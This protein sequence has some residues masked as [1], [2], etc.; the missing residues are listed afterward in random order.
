M[1]GTW[2]VT[3]NRWGVGPNLGRME[4]SMPFSF[5][6]LIPYLSSLIPLLL[7]LALVPGAKAQQGIPHIGY[8]YP[9]GGRQGAS[10]QVKIGGQF[11]SGATHAYVSGAGIQAVV[12]ETTKP[13][14]QK[15][16]KNLRERLKELMKKSKDAAVQKE[17]A[18]IRKKLSTFAPKANPFLAETVQ[19]QVTIAPD[20]EPGERELRLGTRVGLS[21]PLA[22]HVSQQPE[23]VENEP[24]S[25]KEP[26]PY[27]K[28]QF[29]RFSKEPARNLTEPVVD[30]TLPVIVNGQIL[31]G[32]VDYYRFKA[33]KGQQLV[34]VAKAR[35]LIPYLA[36]AVPG[37]F[38]AVLALYDAKG[39]ELAYENNFRFHPDPVLSCKIPSDGEYTLE[40]RDALYR[41]REDF[42]YR[43]TLAELPFVTSIFPLGGRAGTQTA[44]QME[45]WNLPQNRLTVDTKGRDPGTFPLFFKH[46]GLASNQ[47]P[48]AVDTLPEC[49]EQ[50][51]NNQPPSAQKV[52]LP[53]IVNG[54]I[55]VPGDVDVFQF[56]GRA[57][58]AL[59]A[60][61]MAR[62]LDSP[63]D[64]VLKLTDAAGKQLAF[65]DDHEDKGSG[66]NTHH[67]DS[68]IRT[69][70]P[71]DGTYYLH[72]SD[73][74]RQGSSAHAYRLRISSPRPDFQLRLV[75]SS[76]LARPG[77]TVPITVY[78]LRKDG[79]NQK[80]ALSLKSALK[81]FSLGG[82]WVPP[83][84]DQIRL[85]LTV[86]PD[87]L[88]KPFNLQLE[89]RAM[90][91]GQEIVHP[92]VPADDL[93]QAFFYHHLVPAK[94]LMVTVLGGTGRPGPQVKLLAEEPVKLSAGGTA[95]VRFTSSRGGA[96][97]PQLELHEPPE[98]I[99]IQKTSVDRGSVTLVLSAD[100]KVK[101]G[102][103][104]NLIVQASP[105][106]AAKAPKPKA[107]P[108]PG[109]VPSITLP[110]IP[111]E[112][113]K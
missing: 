62:R 36:D 22:F 97:S 88:E 17:I 8:V 1:H 24:N 71:A 42:V 29:A 85:T 80:I 100:P 64:S 60:E 19:L 112:I 68:L 86:P 103:Q 27:K 102:L 31:P 109:R 84:Q 75:P 20:A 51:P 43:L 9:A 28:P 5:S 7:L 66:L 6:S 96:A 101:P 4:R 91:Q 108:N 90:I 94:N 35:D 16:A 105:G 55:D 93:M 18:E 41:G 59:V 44:V 79:F 56:E 92:V 30:V 76:I 33:T 23:F 26:A 25:S 82:G 45:G 104:G 106:R 48:F 37:W 83:G 11:V 38:Q 54:R 52:S 58:Q 69:T 47:V 3:R 113:V 87:T 99:T 40:I 2:V 65:N 95:T 39:N 46:Q 10:F 67:A 57:G 78:A 61:V 81:G 12:V 111:F 110:A 15:E 70:L 14:T 13:I 50:E 63:L 72:L 98:G 32:D 74:Q 34:V 89:G 77:M 107:K 53:I 49:L 21:N 73:A